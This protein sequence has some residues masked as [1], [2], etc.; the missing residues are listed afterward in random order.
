[1]TSGLA[2]FGNKLVLPKVEPWGE[3]VYWMY[4]IVLGEG[5]ARSRDEVMAL[6]ND[7]GVET[8][9]VFYPM[10]VL[11]PYEEKGAT[12]PAAEHCAARGINLPTHG[13]L[14]EQDIDR[15]VAALARAID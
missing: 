6:M 3:H 4:T 11:P 5:V 15:V 12:Y 14:S 9:P 2:R 7:Q 13:M 8:R 10:H 1:M